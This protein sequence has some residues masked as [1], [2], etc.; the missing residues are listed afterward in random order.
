MSNVTDRL[1]G[2][3]SSLAI[4]APVSAATTANIT[5]S[6]EQT[7]DGV[8]VVGA[9]G[10]T[11][12]DRVLVKNQ[13]TASE[14]GIYDVST[15]A[16]RR[17]SDWDGVGDIVKGTR[18]Y[19]SSGTTN[20]GEWVVTT[21]NPIVIGT[22][23]VALSGGVFYAAI[24]DSDDI[25]QGAA[26]L[27]LTVAERAKLTGFDVSEAGLV[28][29][30]NS[31]TAIDSASWAQ[32]NGMRIGANLNVAGSGV[33]GSANEFGLLI[34]TN[35][36]AATA[37]TAAYE[38]CALLVIAQTSDPST[39]YDR[40]TVGID[41]RG[42]IAADNALGRAWG[43]YSEGRIL[44]GGDGLLYAHE[45]FVVNNGTDQSL[46]D[47]TTSKYG[48]HIVA[49]GAN[50]STAG[51]KFSGSGAEFHTGLY[52]SPDAIVTHV[53]HSSG[54]F[55]LRM[56]GEMGFGTDTPD[57]LVHAEVADAGT[58]TVAYAARLSHVTSGTAAVGLGVGM[59]HEIENASGNNKVAGRQNTHWLTATD[60]SEEAQWQM[61][62][63][64]AG[65]L[66][67]VATIDSFGLITATGAFAVGANQVMGARV[68]G[69]VTAVGTANKDAS[70]INVGTIT[71]SDANIRAVAAWVKSIHDALATH[72]AIGA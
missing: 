55:S 69:F 62:L 3:R 49:G 48:L 31:L 64:H 17:S 20:Q 12:A 27:F 70:A 29:I 47:T 33:G 41:M 5:L 53:M 21:A 37:G 40:D 71:A 36:T 39:S 26:N 8:A 23:S 38:K 14:N 9:V 32:A 44:T 61:E 65:V 28:T 56:T 46:V 10:S 67:S 52:F 51:I 34:H 6:G 35:T 59:E 25:T 1:R 24:N 18:V 15:G 68:T 63:M 7:I 16:W 22:T 58:A 54:V 4:K 30:E 19:V 13:N 43:G 72:G 50:D 60:S 2:V 57:R 11:A 66:T 45:F 42:Y